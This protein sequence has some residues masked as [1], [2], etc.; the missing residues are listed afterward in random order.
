MHRV[1]RSSR[2]RAEHP[3]SYLLTDLTLRPRRDYATLTNRRNY[4]AECVERGFEFWGL[5]NAGGYT[6][7]QSTCFVTFCCFVSPTSDSRLRIAVYRDAAWPFKLL[8]RLQR[9][10][11]PDGERN[12][13]LIQV[14][15]SVFP[16]TFRIL[17]SRDRSQHTRCPALC[18]VKQATVNVKNETPGVWST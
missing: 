3:Y 11:T 9:A 14:N 18:A 5:E 17:G 15:C 13:I 16:A 10:I 7:G 4:D 6:V 8:H 2:Q 1:V 12:L